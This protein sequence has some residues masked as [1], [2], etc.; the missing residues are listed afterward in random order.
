[1][2]AKTI[3]NQA[4]SIG[5]TLYT[6]GGKLLAR[7]AQYLTDELRAAIKSH[8]TEL[9]ELLTPKQKRAIIRFR[10]LNGQGGVVIGSDTDTPESLI[11]DLNMKYGNRLATTGI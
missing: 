4:L 2:D 11:D 3:L 10:L 1:M 6:Q 5:V 9:L 8:K 7:N